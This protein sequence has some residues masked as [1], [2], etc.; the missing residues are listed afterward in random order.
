MTV[1]VKIEI[2]GDFESLSD[3]V[4]ILQAKGAKIA[5]RPIIHEPK[6]PDPAPIG[7]EPKILPKFSK[8][9][10]QEYLPDGMTLT[11]YA[12]EK[13]EEAKK[14]GKDIDD[15][16]EEIK[17]LVF[18]Y[19]RDKRPDFNTVVL[20]QRI[21]RSMASIKSKYLTGKL[22]PDSTLDE[23]GTATLVEVAEKEDDDEGKV[24]FADAGV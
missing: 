9:N 17:N 8:I 16:T 15:A 11:Q 2:E 1:R 3:V 23:D 13:F 22:N 12:L 18:S 10:F 21:Y 24:G 4:A 19:V 6:E 20:S 14:T 7:P 5:P